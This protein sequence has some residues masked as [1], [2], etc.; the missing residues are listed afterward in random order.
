MSETIENLLEQRSSVHGDAEQQ[1]KIAQALKLLFRRYM[2]E[3]K[4]DNLENATV[5][6]EALDMI[7]VKMSRIF[8]GI[9]DFDDHWKDIAGYATIIS[10]FIDKQKTQEN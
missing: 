7:A 9:A 4:F 8:S 10:N 6:E 5:I 3:A 2:G 1:F